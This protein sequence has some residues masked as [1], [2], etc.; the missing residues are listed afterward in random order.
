[1][2]EPMAGIG[3]ADLYQLPTNRLDSMAAIGA[4]C[5]QLMDEHYH[6][7]NAI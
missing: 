6:E 7:E 2:F 1:M 5:P 4:V 3:H